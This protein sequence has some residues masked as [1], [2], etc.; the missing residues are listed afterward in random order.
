MKKLLPFLIIS[1]LIFASCGSPFKTTIKGESYQ[2]EILKDWRRVTTGDAQNY[3][4]FLAP[5]EPGV[6]ANV[7]IQ[8][9]K[10]AKIQWGRIDEV[11]LD[12]AAKA[13]DELGYTLISDK[14]QFVP[15]AQKEQRYELVFSADYE[16]QAYTV[17]QHLYA[18]NI[19]VI[20]VT[21]TYPEN[22]FILGD[23]VKETMES[24]LL[25]P[26]NGW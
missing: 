4:V 25:A 10:D 3:D 8:S 2:I 15:Q 9:Q 22:D 11:T 6:S 16:G 12:Y 21:G 18:K 17:I 1:I 14:Y 23:K 5:E 24:F 13:V 19:E 20:F 26:K 7:K